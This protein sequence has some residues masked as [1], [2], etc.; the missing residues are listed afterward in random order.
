MPTAR[1]VGIVGGDDIRVRQLGRGPHF[2]AKPLDRRCVR[3]VFHRHHFE[4]DDAAHHQMFGLIHDAHAADAEQ[5]HH[6]VARVIDQLGRNVQRRFRLGNGS[7]SHSRLL[8][9]GGPIITGIG[10]NGLAKH[11][12]IYRA[13]RVPVSQKIRRLR[14]GINFA[15]LYANVNRII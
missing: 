5:V 2:A 10:W 8:C 9:D 4:R 7:K 12:A 15:S 1:F 6:P 14:S 13:F 3:G 11:E